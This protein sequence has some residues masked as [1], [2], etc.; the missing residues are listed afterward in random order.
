MKN[1]GIDEKTQELYRTA[2]IGIEKT[3]K[4]YINVDIRIEEKNAI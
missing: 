2:D 3:Q 4:L 1:I